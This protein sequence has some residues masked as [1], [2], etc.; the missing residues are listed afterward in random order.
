[1]SLISR[2]QTAHQSVTDLAAHGAGFFKRRERAARE[3][4]RHFVSRA[5][6]LPDHADLPTAEREALITLIEG[7]IETIERYI[8]RPGEQNRTRET[9]DQAF[10]EAVYQLKDA[11]ERVSQRKPFRV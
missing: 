4:I 10:A 11:E 8:A 1:M 6:S 7:T 9:A 5:L 2:A 3:A